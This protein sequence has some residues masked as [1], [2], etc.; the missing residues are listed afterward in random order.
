MSQTPSQILSRLPDK[1][2]KIHGREKADALLGQHQ[3]GLIHVPTLASIAS[4]LC[5]MVLASEG[6]MTKH[7]V[8]ASDFLALGHRSTTS[9]D[10]EFRLGLETSHRRPGTV[11]F[12]PG[13]NAAPDPS[14]SLEG[15][16]C[17][18]QLP[19][20]CEQAADAT[21]TRHLAS[22]GEIGRAHV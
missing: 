5:D 2:R 15:I 11:C 1:L 14:T 9:P 17:R 21:R 16:G 19:P 7:P 13:D 12:V 8:Q 4:D 20:V 22:R 18:W 6:S 3:R 10:D